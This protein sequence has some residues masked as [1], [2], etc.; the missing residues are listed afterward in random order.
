MPNRILI[1]QGSEF[2]ETVVHVAADNGALHDHICIEA[3]SSFGLCKQY[4][5]Q[6]RFFTGNY[7]VHTEKCHGN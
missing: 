2:G 6:I 3:H 1:D 5:D 7:D 4:N